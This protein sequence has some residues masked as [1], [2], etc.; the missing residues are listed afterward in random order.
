MGI[1]D[2][3][4]VLSLG[5]INNVLDHVI[6]MNSPVA[7]AQQVRDLRTSRETVDSAIADSIGR[8]NVLQKTQKTKAGRVAQ[9][10]QVITEI[11]SDDDPTNDAAATPKMAEK[12]RLEAELEG[13]TAKI[14]EEATTRGT[15]EE[16]LGA[17]D[18]RI[19]ELE[20]RLEALKS[21]E[22]STRAKEEAVSA[23]KT[24]RQ[25]LEVNPGSS[26]DSTLQRAEARRGAADAHLARE[27]GK[28]NT[29]TDKTGRNT[30][31]EAAVAA[32]K[33]Q[34]AEQKKQQVAAE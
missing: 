20:A 3:L 29:L 17:I 2:K 33:R 7:I 10:V 15:L 21:T 1:F 23:L 24:A 27:V 6:D 34:L 25:A 18:G 30:E 22:S 32:F 31:A 13:I 14:A 28:L 11:L 26:V 12:L 8:V 4:R 5:H 19:S 9:L 16:A